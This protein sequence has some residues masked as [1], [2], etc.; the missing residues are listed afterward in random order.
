MPM[1]ACIF[2]R[3]KAILGFGPALKK[4]IFVFSFST[5]NV[6]MTLFRI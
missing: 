4:Q 3:P 5:Y 2:K 1:Y 6:C